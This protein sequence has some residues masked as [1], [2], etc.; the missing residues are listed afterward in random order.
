MGCDIHCYIEHRVKLLTSKYDERWQSFGGRINPGRNYDIFAKLAGVRSYGDSERPKPKGLPENLGYYAK[1]DSRLFISEKQPDYEGNCSPE[2]AKRWIES[3]S[4]KM[5][6]EHWVT[7]PDHHSHSWCDADELEK[8]VGNSDEPEYKAVI[9][10][11][12]S[13]E[14]QGRISRLVYWFDN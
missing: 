14:Q 9:A 3:G 5:D 1:S 2:S 6:G 7:H 4:S 13:F 11:M 8:A 10:A 12:R